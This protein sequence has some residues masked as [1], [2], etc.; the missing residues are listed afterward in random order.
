MTET[1]PFDPAEYLDSEEGIEA[2]LAD[3]RLDGAAALAD[4]VEVVARARTL[5]QQGESGQRS[6]TP[7]QHAR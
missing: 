4:A 7:R 3:A 5:M 6:P 1:Y 2:Y